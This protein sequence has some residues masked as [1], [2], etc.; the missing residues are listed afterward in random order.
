MEEA[1]S[2]LPFH[3]DYVRKLFKKE[4]GQTPLGY[5]TR[6]RMKKA[7]LML[8]SNWSRDYS[9]GEIAQ[10]CGYENALYF[11]RLFHQTYGRSPSD[12]RLNPPP[13]VQEPEKPVN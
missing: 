1:I 13:A 3:Y 11:S 8:T 12:Y 6:L 9:V 5:L 7:E 10:L 2:G 4:M